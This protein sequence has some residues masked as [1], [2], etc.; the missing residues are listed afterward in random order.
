MREEVSRLQSE[1]AGYLRVA[2]VSII[3]HVKWQHHQFNME[4]E[5][6]QSYI[7]CLLL[8]IYKILQVSY[9]KEEEGS[10]SQI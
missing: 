5:P 6:R 8:L 3:M 9:E 7:P 10:N 4:L 2:C 1:G